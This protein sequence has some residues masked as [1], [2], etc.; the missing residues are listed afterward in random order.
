MN[1]RTTARLATVTLVALL[2]LGAALPAQA[3]NAGHFFLPSGECLQ[4]GSFHDAPLVGPSREELDLV[5]QTPASLGYDEYG[6][7]YIGF[8][9]VTGQKQAPVLPGP[10]PVT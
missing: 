7:S 9:D 6:A 8:L 10:L 4:I 5:P 3:H 2:P 1:V